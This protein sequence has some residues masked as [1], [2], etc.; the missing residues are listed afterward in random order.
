MPQA[1]QCFSFEDDG[2]IPNSPLPVLVYHDV[3][4]ATDAGRCVRLFADNSW[5]GA[6]RDGIYAFHHFHSNAHEVLGVVAGSAWVMLGGPN[7]RELEIG[8]GDVLVLPAG[9]GHCKL[10]GQG[11]LVVGAYPDG[12][13]CDVC[14]GEPAEHDAAVARI[15]AVPLPARDPVDGAGGPLLSLWGA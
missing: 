7:G 4:E 12:M 6:W 15:G 10:G 1:P 13:Q 2:A 8:W 5:L 14:R 3:P 9:T 11:L